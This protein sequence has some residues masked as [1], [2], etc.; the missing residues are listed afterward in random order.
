VGGAVEQIGD[1]DGNVVIGGGQF[2]LGQSLQ[3][4][5]GGLDSRLGANH[6]VEYFLALVLGHMQG[7]QHFEVGS[8]RGKRSA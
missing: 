7:G 8:H 4:A 1:V 2:P 6:V 5:Q 3:R